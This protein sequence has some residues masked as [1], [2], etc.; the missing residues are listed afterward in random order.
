LTDVRLRRPSDLVRQIRTTAEEHPP[1][2]EGLA[3]GA[4]VGA[5]IAGSTLWAKLRD[6]RRQQAAARVRSEG[7]LG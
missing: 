7:P 3:L 4:L 6:A 5:A 2:L 1:F